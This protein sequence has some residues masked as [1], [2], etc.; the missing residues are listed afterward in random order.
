MRSPATG[1]TSFVDEAGNFTALIR[2]RG[3]L[4]GQSARKLRSLLKTGVSG[5]A[6]TRALANPVIGYT[7]LVTDLKESTKFYKNVLGLRVLDS[8]ASQVTFDIGTMILTLKPEPVLGLVRSLNKSHRLEGDWV[9]F[10]V[11]DIEA[12]MK[13]LKSRGVKFPKGIEDSVHARG[14]YFTDVDGYSFGLWIPPD[15]PDQIDYFPQLQRILKSA[16]WLRN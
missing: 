5:G 2:P 14:A 3:A 13:T 12:D 6:K 8:S 16:T 7:L 4:K 1:A 15:K 10:R 9:V 11:K